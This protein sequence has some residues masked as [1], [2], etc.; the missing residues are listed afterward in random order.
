MASFKG[1]G[2]SSLST[3]E[4]I[5]GL[6]AQLFNRYPLLK[7]ELA[8]ET[9]EPTELRAFSGGELKTEEIIKGTTKTT[10]TLETEIISWATI[11]LALGEVQKTIAN[12]TM[13]L[14]KRATVPDVGPFTVADAD[15]VAGNAASVLVGLDT[16]GP[17]GQAGSITR[18]AAAPAIREVQVAAGTLT[19]NA[20][21]AGAPVSYLL[22]K[23]YASARVY[24]GP[25]TSTQL[26][27]MQFFGHIFDTSATSEKGGYIWI[28]RMESIGAP[29]I[30]FSDGTPTLSS[31]F[32]CLAISTYPG[33]PYVMVDGHQ[34]IA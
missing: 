30:S 34:L 15:I 27:R 14:V 2:V 26:G 32:Q 12:F 17:W 29:T 20:A 33:R 19:F 3:I 22:N 1:F 8:E 31:Q 4:M 13:P 5:G 21:Q 7:F 16:Q 24:G 28:P 9:G 18:S 23:T 25:G 11:G 6:S 10:L